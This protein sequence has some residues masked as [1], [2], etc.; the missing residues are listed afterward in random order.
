M[1]LSGR[2][3]KGMFESHEKKKTFGS[4]DMTME[5]FKEGLA[6]LLYRIC[7]SL[8]TTEYIN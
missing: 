8:N 6:T 1:L 7:K 2:Q 5:A 3:E 4:W